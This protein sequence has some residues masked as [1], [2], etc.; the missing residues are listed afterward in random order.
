MPVKVKLSPEEKAAGRAFRET[1]QS[2]AELRAVTVREQAHSQK[3]PCT[4]VP[5]FLAQLRH[6]CPRRGGRSTSLDLREV[7]VYS[8]A[9][10]VW[11]GDDGKPVV[12]PEPPEMPPAREVT[13][14]Q[15]GRFGFITR[16][17]KCRCGHV[18]VSQAGRLVD[19]RE[20]APLEGRVAR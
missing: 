6:E 5:N 18:A 4:L 17:G 3:R 11:T 20:R 19:A 9:Y 7:Y 1:A 16:E 8:P 14:I 10:H 13:L 15:A 12:S 2:Y